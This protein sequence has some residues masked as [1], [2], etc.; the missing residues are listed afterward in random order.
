MIKC[1]IAH[2][3]MVL[4]VAAP[5]GAVAVATDSFPGAADDDSGYSIVRSMYPM[6]M[7]MA[8]L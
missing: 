1:A 8:I 4:R 3:D 2:A 5:K 7:A 6:V